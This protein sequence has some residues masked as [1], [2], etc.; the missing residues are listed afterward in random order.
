MRPIEDTF[1]VLYLKWNLLKDQFTLIPLEGSKLYS[2][3]FHTWNRKVQLTS[4][5]LLELYFRVW[6]L[7]CLES[8]HDAFTKDA[9]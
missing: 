4:P 6:E 9:F 2:R 1:P 7:Q 8:G 5:F 3:N